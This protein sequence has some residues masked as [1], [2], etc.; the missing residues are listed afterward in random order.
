MHKKIVF[1]LVLF[2]I[3][4]LNAAS[5]ITLPLENLEA[6]KEEELKISNEVTLQIQR[7]IIAL[8]FYATHHTFEQDELLQI[9]TKFRSKILEQELEL[10]KTS[11]SAFFTIV[12]L[13]ENIL[14]LKKYMLQEE[15]NFLTTYIYHNAPS[16]IGSIILGTVTQELSHPNI[17]QFEF[18]FITNFI[19]RFFEKK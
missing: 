14:F 7:R 12:T 8:T 1:F 11:S 18:D 4:S 2:F 10:Y 15:A 9:F 3:S 13:K 6:K 5:K 17:T 16:M 19:D